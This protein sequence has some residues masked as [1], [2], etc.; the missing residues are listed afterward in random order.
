MLVARSSRSLEPEAMTDDLPLGP[1]GIGLDSIAI[2]ELLLDCEGRFGVDGMGLLVHPEQP[3]T[4]RHLVDH[5][6]ET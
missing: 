2:A 1:E 3:L 6:A 5:V 4:V